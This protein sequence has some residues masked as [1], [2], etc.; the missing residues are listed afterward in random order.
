MRRATV[1]GA[2]LVIADSEMDAGVAAASMA[3]EQLTRRVTLDGRA[4][5]ILATG[6][7]QVAFLQA[8]CACL[9]L[10]WDRITV[11]HMDEYVGIAADHPASFRRYMHERLVDLV[12]PRAFYPINGDALDTKAEL[13]RYAALLA[14]EPPALCVMG[15]GENGHLA[16]NDPPA[17]FDAAERIQVVRLSDASRYQQVGEG[18]F[19]TVGDVPSHAITLTIPTLLAPERV[20][21]VVPEERKAEAVLAALEGPISPACPASILRRTPGVTIILDPDSAAL[22]NRGVGS[23]SGV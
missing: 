21:V 11:F 7:S 19:A 2:Q 8:L 14:A 23:F 10:P 12:R 1:E 4:S 22:L 17:D 9:D 6:N 15:I 16:F 13:R 3:A 18:H 20:L 5:V